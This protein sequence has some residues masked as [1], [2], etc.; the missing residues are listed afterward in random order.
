MTRQAVGVGPDAYFGPYVDITSLEAE[1]PAADNI[2]RRGFVGGASPATWNTYESILTGWTQIGTGGAAVPLS[3]IAPISENTTS[4]IG[5]GVMAARNDHIHQRLSSS[6][7][8]VLDGSGNATV[9]YTRSFT[10][11]PVFSFTPL[12]STGQPIIIEHTGDIQ[13]GSLFTG[14]TIRGSRAQILPQ[15]LVTLLLSGVFNL[16]SGT[17]ASGVSVS[18]FVIQPSA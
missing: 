9:T 5:T 11:A 8:V 15:N 14:C 17:S 18:C 7:R 6:T 13:T 10:T 4:A 12:N 3:S 1:F 16:F 2:G